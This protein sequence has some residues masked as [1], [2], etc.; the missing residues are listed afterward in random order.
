MSAL[1]IG[2]G[3]TARQQADERER[4]VDA[5]VTFLG[6]DF[7]SSADPYSPAFQDR[8]LREAIERAASTMDAGLRDD[9]ATRVALHRMMATV[10]SNWGEYEKAVAHLDRAY[11][12]NSSLSGQRASEQVL[13]D[14]AMCQ[15]LRLAGEPRRAERI[16]LRGE[17]AARNSGSS[18]LNAARIVRAKLQFEIGEYDAAA[19]A[20]ADA[21]EQ[22]DR[23]SLAERA[24]AEWFHGLSLR[25]LAMFEPAEAALRRHLVLRRTLH[26]ETHPLTAWAHADYGDL[27]VDTGDFVGAEQQLERAGQIF[28]ATL[29]AEHPESLSPAYSR[30]VADLWRGKAEDARLALRPLVERYRDTLGADHF[31]TLYTMSELALA[32][33]LTGEDERAV[34]LLREARQTGARVLYGRESKAAHFHLRWA[35][36][37]AAL[38]KS[39]EAEDERDRALIAMDRAGLTSDHPWRGRLHC[40]TAGS[41]LARGD[42]SE[43]RRAGQACLS[44]LDAIDALPDSYPALIEARSLAGK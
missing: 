9:P 21:L 16:C 27:L 25:K 38:G 36:A 2:W 28:N 39:E 13:I 43:S 3:S 31:W 30:A 7:F 10:F 12:L 32:E 40:I 19:E 22:G 4:Q 8:S 6:S 33:A 26:G 34:A 1:A 14:I 41:A 35:R 23:L 15:N 42:E 24:D 29:G 37:L 11:S 44:A 17:Q 18:H 5:L 20:L